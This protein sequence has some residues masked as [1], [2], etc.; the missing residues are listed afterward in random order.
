MV[1][2]LRL[3]PGDNL[4]Q[5]EWL[6]TMLLK[7]NRNADALSFSQIWLNSRGTI[8]LRGGCTFE[9]PSQTPLSAER[10][11]KEKRFGSG[12]QNYTAALASFRLWGDCELARQYLR[13]A[14]ELNPHVIRRVLGK[15]TRPSK[16]SATWFC[17]VK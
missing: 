3:C 16:P 9:P 8:P 11:A 14:T 6:G 7:A 1:E 10:Y 12:E 2:M 13:I 4:S 17:L 15:V 5:R